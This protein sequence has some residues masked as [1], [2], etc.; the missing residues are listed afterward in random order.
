MFLLN[1]LEIEFNLK[2]DEDEFGY[3]V[4]YFVVLNERMKKNISKKICI[5]CYY[6][7]GIG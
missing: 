3:I 4:I 2:F 1:K 6:G 7:I 5:V